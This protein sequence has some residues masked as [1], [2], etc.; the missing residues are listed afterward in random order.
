MKNFE[1]SIEKYI[2]LETKEQMEQYKDIN[3][4]RYETKD[5]N[6]QPY[7]FGQFQNEVLRPLTVP[8]DGKDKKVKNI[9]DMYIPTKCRGCEEIVTFCNIPIKGNGHLYFVIYTTCNYSTWTSREYGEDMLRILS[10]YNV[11][12][13]SYIKYHHS[14]KRVSNLSENIRKYLTKLKKE[15]FSDTKSYLQSLTKMD[16]Y[17]FIDRSSFMVQRDIYNTHK[18]D[19]TEK[20]YV[21]IRLYF[22]FNAFNEKPEPMYLKFNEY[23][24]TD[25]YIIIHGEKFEYYKIWKVFPMTES[26]YNKAKSNYIS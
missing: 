14:M 23:I 17:V 24:Y 4:K 18:Y 22:N 2:L 16:S 10:L 7:T 8:K 19:Y 13:Y 9:F 11:N 3:R 15:I 1:L 20:G 12:G 26:Q 6:Y 25:D 21:G 5:K